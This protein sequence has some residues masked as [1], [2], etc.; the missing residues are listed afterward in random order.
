[1]VLAQT[2]MAPLREDLIPTRYSLLSRL[3]NWDDQES[4]KD[5]FDTYWRL[6]YN[7]AV[8]S[9]LNEAEAQD[10]VQETVICVAKDIEKFKRERA[11]GSFK[12]WLRNLTRWR[13]R[14]QLR[15]RM[16]EAAA[17]DEAA[18]E[19]D[20][21]VPLEEIVSATASALEELWDKEW[22]ENLFEAA[23]DRVKRQ[24]KEEHFQ[25]FDLYVVKK[26]PVEKV[27]RTLGVNSGQ[28]YLAKHR[29][30]SLIKKE[31]QRLEKDLI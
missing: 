8:N 6:I 21:Q 28:V 14:D 26:W 10:V 9:G 7:A 3:Q 18:E 5:F 30:G 20:G 27:A 31:V 15:K 19:K 25:M 2:I 29:V 11:K 12:G 16:P 17:K 4:W 23:V 13:I 22:Q 1:M 24:V